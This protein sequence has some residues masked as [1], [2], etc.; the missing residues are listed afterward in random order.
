MRLSKAEARREAERRWGQ[1]PTGTL[2]KIMTANYSFGFAAKGSDLPREGWGVKFDGW[3]HVGYNVGVCHVYRRDLP[4]WGWWLNP[5][6]CRYEILGRGWSFEEAL[7]DADQR[8]AEELEHEQ[9]MVA[10]ADQVRAKWDREDDD[11]DAE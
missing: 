7:M 11:E 6:V 9:R 2:E 8:A 1:N 10:Y 4:W 3:I 5:W